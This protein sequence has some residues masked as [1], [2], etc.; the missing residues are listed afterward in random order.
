VR[1]AG[2]HKGSINILMSDV[3]MP[4]MNGRQLAKDLLSVYPRLKCVFM[5]GWTAEILARPGVT[6]PGIHFLQKPFSQEQLA[7][8]LQKASPTSAA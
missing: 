2:E 1:L 5:S 6:E 4:E 7:A 3:I 8:A